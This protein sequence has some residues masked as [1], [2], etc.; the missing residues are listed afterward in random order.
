MS[1]EKDIESM[2]GGM[3]SVVSNLPKYINDFKKKMSKE[4]I[5]KME[6]TIK[7]L[8][9]NES[10]NEFSKAKNDFDYFMKKNY[11]R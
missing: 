6:E 8:N 1:L 5:A 7:S 11:A 9:V 10:L 2:L 3:N 4:D